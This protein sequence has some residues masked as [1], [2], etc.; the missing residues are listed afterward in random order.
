MHACTRCRRILYSLTV[1]TLRDMCE[2]RG[3]QFDGLRKPELIEALRRD[4]NN[5]N[6]V[7]DGP[8]DV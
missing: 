8:G 7:E 2:S 4:D 3:I 5:D 1:A 6:E